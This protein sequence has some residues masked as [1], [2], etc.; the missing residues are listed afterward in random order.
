[1]TAAC[2]VTPTA[3]TEQSATER[4]GI[5]PLVPLQSAE[6]F[7][8]SRS[9]GERGERRRDRAGPGSG[10]GAA[11][12]VLDL[13]IPVYNEEADLEPCVRRVHAYLMAAFPY[14]FQITIADNASADGTLA[15]AAGLAAE[16]PRVRVVHLDHK[17]RGHALKAAWSSS[18]A[19]VLAYMD[20]DLSTDLAA[21]LPLV[22]PLIS[23]HSRTGRSPDPVRGKPRTVHGEGRATSASELSTAMP[24]RD[25]SRPG[26]YFCCRFG[27]H[28]RRSAHERWTA[29]QD[30]AVALVDR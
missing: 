20:V 23:G 19:L 28:R 17:G 27:V 21:L 30:K 2:A 5:R 4:S 16:L 1:M 29:T 6:A 7:H 14:S 13:V 15:V 25:R 11:R 18:P 26:G 12:P 22:A 24:A 3:S 10:E 8:C 9:P